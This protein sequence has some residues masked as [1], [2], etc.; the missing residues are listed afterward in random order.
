M[1]MKMT[2]LYPTMTAFRSKQ[3][4]AEIYRQSEITSRL[5]MTHRIFRTKVADCRPVWR[6]FRPNVMVFW[7]KS[8]VSKGNF[9]ILFSIVA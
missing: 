9:Y 7:S 5:M 6:T 1:M 2:I 3:V 8:K 4:I